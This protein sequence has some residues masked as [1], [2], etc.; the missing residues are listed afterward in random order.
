M[1]LH[2][3]QNGQDRSRRK[4]GDMPYTIEMEKVSNVPLFSMLTEKEMCMLSK[5]MRR[6]SY[7]R[8]ALVLAEGSDAESLYVILSGRIKV[9]K[10]D[11][12]GREII[13]AVLGPGEYFGEMALLDDKPRS[14]NV[15][16]VEPS[17]IICISK[18]DFQRCLQDN[19]ELSI[20][21]MRGLVHR[22]R[23]ADRSISSLALLD[24]YGRVAR[25]VLDHSEEVGGRKILPHRL[26]HQEIASRVGASREM[27][28]RVMR[29]FCQRGL[30][31]EEGNQ[32]IILNANQLEP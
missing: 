16:T 4:G 20:Y 24:V 5:A 23:N 14:A 15:E 29:I 32:V 1:C 21:I 13:L 19:F 30:I 6:V 2:K 12:D 9:V 31:A 11:E 25:L 22:L 8:G 7:G 17:D 27:V 10:R 18:S 28:G 3:K 26:S